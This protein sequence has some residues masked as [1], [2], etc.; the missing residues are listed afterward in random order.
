MT[1]S[2]LTCMTSFMI[3]TIFNIFN[4]LFNIFIN[5][6]DIEIECNINKFADDMKLSGTVDKTEGWDAIQRKMDTLEKLTYKNLMAND[7][8]M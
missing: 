2:T 5:H 1:L 6:I 7:V 4:M 8:L 3:Q